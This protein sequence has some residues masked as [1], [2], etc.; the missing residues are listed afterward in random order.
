[1]WFLDVM[2]GLTLVLVLIH[3]ATMVTVGVYM[4]CCNVVFF[5]HVSQ[6][7]MVVVVVGVLIVL[8]VVTIGF[9]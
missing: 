6:I 8:V 2:E 5:M 3:V 9:V 7:M 4:V 1:M